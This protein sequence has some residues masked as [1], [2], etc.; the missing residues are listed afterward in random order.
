MVIAKW[1]KS[2]TLYLDDGFHKRLKRGSGCREKQNQSNT[3]RR[4]PEAQSVDEVEDLTE[5]VHDTSSTFITNIYVD[6]PRVSSRVR[7][8]STWLNDY[9][10]S[11]I[12]DNYPFPIHTS[13]HMA[14][15]VNISE[16]PEPYSYKQACVNPDWIK[17]MQAELDALET[18]ETWQV[19]DFPTGKKLIG[20]R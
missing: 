8:P 3:S 16:I 4:V 2:I 13:T 14:F 10:V 17:A 12:T 20:C 18:N 5:N 19:V 6:P 11:S 1:Q 15:I 9:I 7:K